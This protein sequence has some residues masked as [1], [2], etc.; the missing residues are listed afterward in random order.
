MNYWIFKLAKQELYPDVPDEKY[1]YDN[2]HSIRLKANDIFIYLD[3]RNGYEFTATGLVKKLTKRKPTLKESQRS[4]RVH[5]VFTAHLGEMIWFTT[6]LSIAA[7]T[8]IGKSNRAKLGIVDV[9]LLGWSQS[10]PK[11]SEEMYQTIMNLIEAEKL[12]PTT[13]SNNIDYTVPDTW[14]KTK[15]RKTLSE[16][17]KTIRDRHKHTCVVCGTTFAAVVEVA[18]LS[19]YATDKQ[20]RANPSN[21][22]CLCTFC[23][24]AL[25]RRLIAIKPDGELL[26]AQFIDDPI[27]LHHFKRVNS[28]TRKDWLR[29][30]DTYF[31]ELTVKWFNDNLDN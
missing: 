12:I 11:I 22:V 20:N 31:L 4:N 8:K 3:K 21:G 10:M 17:R 19:S 14:T 28:V 1:V 23:H 16:F 9:N 30:V 18:H 25:D 15:V 7:T 13:I 6:P 27:A 2:T 5:T 29:G 24:R 26:V